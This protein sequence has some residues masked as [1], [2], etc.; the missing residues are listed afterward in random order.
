MGPTGI[1]RWTIRAFEELARIAPDWEIVFVDA[2]A[3]EPDLSRM[4]PNTAFKLLRVPK[5]A[6]SGFKALR[7]LPPI[8]WLIGPVDAVVGTGYIPWRS[9]RAAEVPVI[10]DLS[11]FR[12]PETVSWK[13]LVYLRMNVP[14]V[15]RRA[16]LV[17]T[18]SESVAAEISA[19]FGIDR[20][21]IEVVF[22]GCDLDVFTPEATV[23]NAIRL[24][25]TY[26]LFV[27]TIEPRKNLMAIL[28]AHDIA[29]GRCPDLP[30]LV[31]VGGKGWRD[32]RVSDELAK[33]RRGGEIVLLGYVPDEAMPGIYA[34]AEFLL[35]PSL[36]EG[37]GMP[38]VEAMAAGC[39]VVTSDR[40]AMAEAAGDAAFLVD[41]ASTASIAAAIVELHSD[42]ALRAVL[43]TE[44]LS[45]AQD[46]TWASTGARLKEALERAAAT[47]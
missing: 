25:Q 12:H 45:R 36:Y 1:G 24:P 3:A 37:F 13:N 29:R 41:P 35:F 5:T 18:I 10:Y 46:F 8:E 15:V 21:R 7:L 31:I 14:R 40:G 33:R 42:P 28:E 23:P 27:G 19:A 30:P 17:I 16:S 20:D 6:Y 9:Q 47:R 38:I 2:A 44:G 39:P 43:V 22:P 26:L 32:S 34:R 4:G 11:F